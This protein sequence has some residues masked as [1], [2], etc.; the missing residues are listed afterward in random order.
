MASFAS[1]TS[2]HRASSAEGDP[3]SPDPDGVVVDVRYC[4]ICATDTHAWA[5]GPGA[6]PP[7][8]FGHEWA[9]VV[10]AVGADVEGFSVG[11]RVAAAV[12]SPCGS[13]AQCRAGH[14]DHCDLVFAEAN[15]IAPSSGDHGGFATQVK[16]PTRRVI[17]VPDEVTDEA[18]AMLEPTAVTFHAV[19]RTAFALGA[20]VVV[21]GAGPIGLL[22]AMHA[23][24]AGAG[25]V[26]VVEPS[27]DRRDV[28]RTLGF[29]DVV[30]PGER[31]REL[32]AQ[33]TDGLGADVLFECTGSAGLLAAS[34][35]L[36]RRGGTLSLLGYTAEPSQVV[37]GD[38]QFREL[39]L[40]G[41]LAYSRIDFT[42]A[43]NAI[44]SGAVL[45][46]PLHTGTVGLS[47]LQ[48]T[49]ELLDSG[50]SPHAKV[51]VDPRR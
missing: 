8:V 11:Q 45:T 37:Y 18:A 17:A 20:L 49:L 1:I 21:Q 51:L 3:C 31:L 27:A 48:E 40:V 46:A 34:S 42:G 2:A 35:E 41:S 47:E 32:L 24:A 14:T 33:L 6:L 19:R 43:L 26:I 23:R 4:G 50:T 12:G 13:C 39:R 15:G 16:V 30:E 36:V 44:R 29:S 7:A 10:S 22:T 25:R 5:A 38:W 28:A 9:G